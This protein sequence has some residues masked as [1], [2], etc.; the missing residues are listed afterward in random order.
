MEEVSLLIA[1]SSSEFCGGLGAYLQRIGGFH[2][3]GVATDGEEA[4]RMITHLRPKMLVLDLM[5]PKRDGLG[6]LKAI[7]ALEEMPV[8]VA[9]SGF[10]SAYVA[11]AAG[12]LGV[13]Y[14]MRKPCDLSVLADRL[15]ELRLEQRNGLPNLHWLDSYG[16]E[17]M[18]A[19]VL[20]EIGVPPHIKGYKYLREAILAAMDNAQMIDAV[21]KVLYPHVAKVFGTSANR[22]ERDIRHAIDLAWVRGDREAFRRLFNIRRKPTNS[23]LIA[24]VADKLLLQRRGS[25]VSGY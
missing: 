6:V 5:L 23:E 17:R 13:R 11:D 16:T 1:D 15:E 4:I 2:V 7:S 20:F 22:V 24:M 8:T 10:L 9:T 12:S 14:V 25:R 18:V 21:T 3:V 19:E